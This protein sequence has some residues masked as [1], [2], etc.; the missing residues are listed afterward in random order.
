M[1]KYLKTLW[2]WKIF[3]HLSLQEVI[4]TICNPM[5]A[6]QVKK[7]WDA[8]AATEAEA[9]SKCARVALQEMNKE[10][11]SSPVLL[12]PHHFSSRSHVW[13]PPA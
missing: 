2:G 6:V 13:P 4:S 8:I 5:M 7:V 1:F 12:A 9:K 10:L 11:G 3:K